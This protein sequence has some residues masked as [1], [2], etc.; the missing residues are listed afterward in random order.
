[1]VVVSVSSLAVVTYFSSLYSA[2]ADEIK[3]RIEKGL[4][5]VGL[6][7]EPVDIGKYEFIRM[8]LKEKWGVLVP[9]DS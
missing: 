6:L 5:D 9:K 4:L 1:M 2:T 8:P 3:Q 7:C